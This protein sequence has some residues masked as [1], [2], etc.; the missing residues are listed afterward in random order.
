MS[1]MA[2]T[3]TTS[4]FPIIIDAALQEYTKQTGIDLTQNPFALKIQHSDSPD[5]VLGL[6]QEREKE[7]KEYRDG[8]RKLINCLKPVVQV[9]HALS[10]VLGETISI[11]S[12][13][14]FIFLISLFI[15]SFSSHFHHQKQS[16]L[17]LM[18]SSQYAS[19][20]IASGLTLLT[21]HYFRP[22]VALVRVMTH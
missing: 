2:S 14:S 19:S 21:S 7:F 20:I 22:L 17:E 15:E 1:S 4:G 9:L 3:P 5:G 18:F 11:V 16:L 10:G 13:T 6:F 8:N 12:L